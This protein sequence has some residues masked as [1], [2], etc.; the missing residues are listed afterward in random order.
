[1]KAYL[2]LWAFC[3]VMVLVA[4]TTIYLGESLGPESKSMKASESDPGWR[5]LEV[6]EISTR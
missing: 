1:V 3:F 4:A 5:Q 6:T 2:T